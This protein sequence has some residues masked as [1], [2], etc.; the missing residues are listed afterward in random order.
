MR[1]AL[2]LALT[3]AAALPMHGRCDSTPPDLAAA[4]AYRGA[5][6]SPRGRFA[7]CFF[8]HFGP[9][10]KS[11][12]E[13]TPSSQVREEFLYQYIAAAFEAAGSVRQDASRAAEYYRYAVA[14]ADAYLELV[15][16]ERT[17]FKVTKV[18]DVLFR[19]GEAYYNRRDIDGNAMQDL[20]YQYE[21]I[22]QGDI[23]GTRCFDK[24][25]VDQWERALRCISGNCRAQ[26]AH[27]EEKIR[28]ERQT[29][30]EFVQ[31]CTSFAQFLTLACE[32]SRLALLK[33]RKEK[34]D[35]YL[36]TEA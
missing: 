11:N 10:N 12:Y 18:R 7:D 4:A 6:D 1:A 15:A 8:V 34:Y 36:R 20:V 21:S 25:S 5:A 19:L 28:T 26:D 2:I 22:A 33:P 9:D 24:R 29:S 32:E 35:N 30:T 13:A 31:R 17:V 16:T 3:F 14:A 27:L 23:C